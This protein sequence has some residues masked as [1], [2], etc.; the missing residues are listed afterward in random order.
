MTRRVV[1]VFG[2]SGFIGR[3]LVRKLTER[4]YVVRAAVR[5]PV[6]AEI[7]RP[8]GDVGQVNLLRV[9]IRDPARVRA[10]VEGATAVVNLVGI[11]AESGGR[12]FRSIHV[13]GAAAVAQAAA[14]AGVASLVHLSALGASKDSPSAYAR[15]KAEGEAAVLAAFPK[16]VIL[17]P[18]VVFGADDNFFNR[19][20]QMARM[21][22][23]LPVFTRDGLKLACHDGMATFDFY[24][25][26]G[27]VF[28]PVWVGDVAQAIVTGL[29]DPELA[30]KTFEL[31]GP[32]RYSFKE[33]MELVLA[34]TERHPLLLPVPFW[35]ARLMAK[36]LQFV[37]GKPLTP[38]QVRL[39]ETDNVVRGGKP[40]LAEMGIAPKSADDIVPAYLQRY[41]SPVQTA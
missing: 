22:P 27:P 29:T 31:G 9:D 40:G 3:A 13:D 30:G 2:A 21:A 14:E 37:P 16:A 35:C 33:L 41:K 20:A 25:S 38:D 12:T 24:G 39:M 28:Q 8:M 36:F 23:A 15:T 11:L 1:T 5:D 18:S 26:G 4:G 7:L 19:F 32:R 17:R 34:A 10:A 6:A